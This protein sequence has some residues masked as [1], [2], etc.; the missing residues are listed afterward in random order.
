MSKIANLLEF[1]SVLEIII[2]GAT[3]GHFPILYVNE[4]T[5]RA[6]IAVAVQTYERFFGRKPCSI[7]FPECG[8]VLKA[9]KYL[10]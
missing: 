4:K 2:C 6:Q 1:F 8:Y 10:R 9:D 5:V 3:H 7:W